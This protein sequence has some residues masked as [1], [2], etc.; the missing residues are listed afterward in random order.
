MYVTTYT[1][2][3]IRTC[4]LIY[5]VFMYMCIHI[6]RYACININIHLH[7]HIYIYDAPVM[8]WRLCGMVSAYDSGLFGK[9]ILWESGTKGSSNAGG[10]R[11]WTTVF[12]TANERISKPRDQAVTSL[13]KSTLSCFTHD[14]TMDG[15]F[16]SVQH[17]ISCFR[18][19]SS[20]RQTLIRYDLTAMQWLNPGTQ[21]E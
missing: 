10:D 19:C 2:I 20:A 18:T 6:C 5:A 15:V 7:L 17:V 14:K 11:K 8:P 12:A 4:I 13:I 21:Y 16:F 9:Q 3:I 1:Y